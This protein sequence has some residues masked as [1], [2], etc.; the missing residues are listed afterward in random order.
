MESDHQERKRRKRAGA[1]WYG[2]ALLVTFLVALAGLVLGGLAFA[3]DCPVCTDGIDGTNG[4][5]SDDQC[6]AT[7]CSTLCN[8]TLVAGA[9]DFADFYA[10][11]PGDNS[12]TVAVGGDVAFPQIGP[13]Q[14]AT[15]ITATST[16]QFEIAEPGTYDVSFFVSVDEAG[17][18]ELTLNGSPV[19]N[20]V[21]GRATGTNYIEAAVLLTV[22]TPASLLT[23]RNPSGNSAALTITPIAGGASAVSAHLK[24]IRLS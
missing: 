2:V 13:A 24:I 8:G 15:G 7:N 4:T 12:A 16:T 23:V 9:L 10:L 3:R 11:M 5:C 22:A 17:Q 20:T 1:F 19:A 18:L 6:Q 14:V 21:T